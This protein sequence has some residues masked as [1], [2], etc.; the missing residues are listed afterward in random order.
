[1]V[2]LD[3]PMVTPPAVAF[4]AAVGVSSVVTATA[5]SMPAGA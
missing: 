3:R 5:S 4:C 2:M 1:M